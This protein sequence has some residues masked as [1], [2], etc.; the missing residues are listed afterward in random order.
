MLKDQ[1]LSGFREFFSPLF[2]TYQ[3]SHSTQQV[4]MQLAEEWV[5][6]LDNNFAVE[7]V[8]MDLSKAFDCISHDLIIAE[9][10]AYGMNSSV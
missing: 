1:L 3:K 9:L 5:G 10:A 8:L 7:A 4:I 2:S 6:S